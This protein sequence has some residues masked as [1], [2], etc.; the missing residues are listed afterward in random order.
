M[1]CAMRLGEAVLDMVSRGKRKDNDK[2][3][4]RGERRPARKPLA[5]V[6]RLG[7]YRSHFYDQS[8]KTPKEDIVLPAR[9]KGLDSSNVR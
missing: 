5:R 7:P 9:G 8:L 6:T 2:I 4:A 3:D 1:T